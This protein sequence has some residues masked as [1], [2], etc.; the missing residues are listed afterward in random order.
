MQGQG[1][2]IGK[3][4]VPYRTY[5]AKISLATVRFLSVAFWAYLNL[6]QLTLRGPD[7]LEM[8]PKA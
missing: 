5:A 2:L 1:P 6:A 4:D 8:N 3:A 7:L